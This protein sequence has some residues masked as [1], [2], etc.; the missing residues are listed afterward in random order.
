MQH[1]G[2]WP[3]VVCFCFLQSKGDKHESVKSLLELYGNVFDFHALDK[4]LN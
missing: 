2:P 3:K 4:Y 1:Q